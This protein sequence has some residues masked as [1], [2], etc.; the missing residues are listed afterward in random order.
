M[1]LIF[2]QDKLL[3]GIDC[4]KK[5]LNYYIPFFRICKVVFL[6]FSKVFYPES[7]DHFLLFYPG[8]AASSGI[9]PDW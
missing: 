9:P 3:I 1:K 5:I 4:A 2:T 7:Q 8:L 6:Q